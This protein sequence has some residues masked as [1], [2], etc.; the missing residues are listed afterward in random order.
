MNNKWHSLSILN[1]TT[2]NV[3]SAEVKIMPD[4]SWFRGHFPGFPIL[5]GIAQLS[6]VYEAVKK[7]N[8]DL[9]IV[10][11]QRV[12]FKQPVK[13]GDIL[14]IKVERSRKQV[15]AYNFIIMSGADPSASGILVTES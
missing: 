9:K 14:K 11:I 15:N 7:F 5:P 1:E 2:E 13:P 8:P 12:K 3:I 4:S 6:M 10:Q